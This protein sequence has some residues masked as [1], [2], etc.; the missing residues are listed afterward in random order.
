MRLICVKLTMWENDIRMTRRNVLTYHY[1]PYNSP[2][3]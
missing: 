1:V 2:W 3:R